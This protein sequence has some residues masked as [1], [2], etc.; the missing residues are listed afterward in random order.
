MQH[1]YL[2]I[3]GNTIT[4]LCTLA[5]G[6]DLTKYVMYRKRIYKCIRYI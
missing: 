6:L 3:K 5:I 1:T 4:D 2:K